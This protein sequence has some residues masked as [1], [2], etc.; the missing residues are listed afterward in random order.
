MPRDDLSTVLYVQCGTMAALLAGF[1]VYWVLTDKWAAV[2]IVAASLTALVLILTTHE[3][4][5]RAL[6][7]RV[8]RIS[9]PS[10]TE[11]P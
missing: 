11:D 3:L 8:S 5:R 6:A 10:A 7:R 2:A 9:W 1:G 4:R